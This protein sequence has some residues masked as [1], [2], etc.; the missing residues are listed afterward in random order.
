MG[1]CCRNIDGGQC[2]VCCRILRDKLL[3]SRCSW[4][5]VCV[6]QISGMGLKCPLTAPLFLKSVPGLHFRG[7]VFSWTCLL[8]CGME[9][10]LAGAFAG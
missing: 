6:L 4:D 3:G 1:V 7:G 8:E 9:L 2:L 10:A 5:V